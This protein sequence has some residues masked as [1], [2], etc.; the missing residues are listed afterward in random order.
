MTLCETFL[1]NAITDS[2]LLINSLNFEGRN[3]LNKKGGGV[4]DYIRKPIPYIRRHALEI[5][6]VETICI[7]LRIQ[8]YTPLVLT[9]VYRP[10]DSKVVRLSNFERLLDN[11]DSFNYDIRHCLVTSTLII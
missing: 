1:H 5:D 7:E 6:T 11:I 9:F 10:P 8:G 3:R 2:S 4:L